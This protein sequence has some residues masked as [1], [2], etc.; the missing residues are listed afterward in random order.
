MVTVDYNDD[1]DDDDDDD[2]NSSS[3]KS[4]EEEKRLNA[5][6]DPL[7]SSYSPD[8]LDTRQTLEWLRGRG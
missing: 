2:D 8:F 4:V 6:S 1:D 7:P 3:L 5:S